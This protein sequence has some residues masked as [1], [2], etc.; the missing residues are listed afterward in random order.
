MAESPRCRV[1][2]KADREPP[3]LLANESLRARRRIIGTDSSAR[4]SSAANIC[5]IRLPD[6]PSD[7]LVGTDTA[8]SPGASRTDRMPQVPSDR[9]YRIRNTQNQSGVYLKMEGVKHLSC[10]L[11]ILNA[12]GFA[13]KFL[14]ILLGNHCHNDLVG[15]VD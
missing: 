9:T 14:S 1:L 15:E 2:V 11:E 8:M 4:E 3:A 12:E 10:G 7:R 5:G 13:S 6:R